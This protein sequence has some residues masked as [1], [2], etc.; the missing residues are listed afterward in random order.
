MNFIFHPSAEKE[1]EQA[2]AYYEKCQ[3]GLGHE[4]LEEIYSTIQR[5]LN[6][7][8]LQFLYPHL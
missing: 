6:F 4:F 2:A 5:I 8:N 1:L 3:I 7:P